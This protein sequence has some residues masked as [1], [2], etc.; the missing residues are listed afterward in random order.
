MRRDIIVIGASS[1]G[2][3]ALKRLVSLLPTNLPAAV[4]ITMHR[5]PYL[6]GLLAQILDQGGLLRVTNAVDEETPRNGH[7]YLA[8]PD[9]H[10]IIERG[11]LRLTRG[12]KENFSRPAIDP[13]FRS[14]ALEY[15]SRVTGVI[16]S[17]TL[18][19]GTAGL[20]AVKHYGGFT[21]VQ[22]PEEAAFSE[23]PEN[24]IAGSRVDRILPMDEI[25][26]TLIRLAEGVE[27]PNTEE[28]NG[29]SMTRDISEAVEFE[30]LPQTVEQNR[31]EQ[32][33][34]DRHGETTIYTC[35][36][37]GGTLWQAGADAGVQ[38]RCHV[39]HAYSAESLALQQGEAIERSLWY[40]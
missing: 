33:Q 26:E 2:L 8:P 4:F 21:I 20:A 10:L 14:A 28:G 22:N 19:D 5:A 37:C 27:V 23:M 24:A 32:V 38:F 25:A 34:G 35:P 6:P 9:R 11:V 40:A 1:G 36:D 29:D 30:H 39:G 31:K 7:F 15:G 13:L 17:G 12:P 3:E 18:Y 16:L